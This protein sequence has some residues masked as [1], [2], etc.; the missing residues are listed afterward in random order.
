MDGSYDPRKHLVYEREC[1]IDTNLPSSSTTQSIW[2][3]FRI[4]FLDDM[5]VTNELGIFER[6][7]L[8]SS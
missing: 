7:N 1:V 6:K 3:L 2:I 8:D 5:E 4:Y